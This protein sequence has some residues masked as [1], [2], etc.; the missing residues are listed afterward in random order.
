MKLPYITL[1]STIQDYLPSSA[2]WSRAPSTGVPLL[3]RDLERVRLRDLDRVLLLDL[4]RDLL[5]DLWV[6]KGKEKRGVSI[7][8]NGTGLLCSPAVIPE[9]RTFKCVLSASK[10]TFIHAT[11]V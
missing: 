4:E 6:K 1:R 8:L 5:R 7:Y 3:D 2:T 11:G 9:L 10:V